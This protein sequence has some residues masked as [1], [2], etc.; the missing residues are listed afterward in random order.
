MSPNRN[1]V[2]CNEPLPEGSKGISC[3]VCSS[4]PEA[5]KRRHSEYL[6]ALAEKSAASPSR[7]KTRKKGGVQRDDGERVPEGYDLNGPWERY[8]RWVAERKARNE[9]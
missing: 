7:Y 4:D 9:Y 8:L 6:A 3:V 1:C 5:A 2:W